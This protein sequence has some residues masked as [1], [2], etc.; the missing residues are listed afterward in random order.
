MTEE[1]PSL[2]HPPHYHGFWPVLLI[3][4]S[5]LTILIWEI[6]VGVFTRTNARQL[7][8]QQQRAVEQANRVQSELE[9]MVRGLVDL[10]KTD[11]EAQRIVRKFGIKV[12]NPTVPA[13]TPAP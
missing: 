11:D 12:N 7:R 6:Q 2:S 10:A 1:S 9:K 5:L 8:E 4:I 13:A 3:G